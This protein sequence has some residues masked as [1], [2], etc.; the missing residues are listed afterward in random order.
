MP[1]INPSIAFHRKAREALT[2]YQ[3]ALGGEVSITTYADWAATGDP[4]AQISEADRDLVI[5]GALRTDAGQRISVADVADAT[6]TASMVS[7]ELNGTPGDLDYIQTAF[8]QFSDGATVDTPFAV[9]A[10]A[11]DE[12]FGTLTDKFGIHWEFGI[13]PDNR[14]L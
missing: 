12:Y 4:E 10:W 6:P 2:F 7:I 11:P 1:R 14:Y 5:A 3:A 9:A 8:E 13:H